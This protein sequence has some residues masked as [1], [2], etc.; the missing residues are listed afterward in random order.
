M[1]A[2]DIIRPAS[3]G[4]FPRGEGFGRT[5]EEREKT[6]AGKAKRHLVDGE[7]RTVPE[8]AAALGL[9][10]QQIYSQMCQRGVSL[11]VAVNLIRENQALGHGRSN[12]FMV[13]GK[14]MT[15][16]QAADSVGVPRTAL[17]DYMYGHG[18][19]PQEAVAAY[20]EGRVTH[21]GRKPI[22]HRVGRRMMTVDEAARRLGVSANAV[23][24]HMR[25]HGVGLATAIRYYEKRKLRLAEKEILGI[26]GF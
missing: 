10:P 18:A 24:L 17:R 5:G 23:H 14:W 12:R 16:Q 22:L 20:R 19:T 7:W 4:T 15:V 21:G 13:D 25:K 2:E 3:R 9:K 11:Q 1:S 6:M 8:M 26:L